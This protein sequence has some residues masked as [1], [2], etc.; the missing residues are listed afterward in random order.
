MRTTLVFSAIFSLSGAVL[1][2]CGEQDRAASTVSVTIKL[3]PVRPA[4]TAPGFSSQG[5]PMNRAA[6]LSNH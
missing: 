1:G 4:E 2:A 6:A 5:L 3:P